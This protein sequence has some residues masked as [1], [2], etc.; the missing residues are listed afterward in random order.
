MQAGDIAEVQQKKE[1]DVV[2]IATTPARLFPSAESFRAIPPP[3][4]S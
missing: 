2:S 1:I 3:A 4:L